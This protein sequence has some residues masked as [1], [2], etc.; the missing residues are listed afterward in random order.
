[1][2]AFAGRKRSQT[3][4]RQVR[5]ALGDLGGCDWGAQGNRTGRQHRGREA[6]S[7]KAA[8]E[9]LGSGESVKLSTVAADEV[10]TGKEAFS[11]VASERTGERCERGRRLGGSVG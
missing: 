11:Q 5:D 10:E 7:G 4:G 3:G 6:R 9:H 1:M 8:G 2:P